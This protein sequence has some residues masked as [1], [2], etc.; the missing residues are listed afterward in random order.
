MLER[1]SS[2]Y[3]KTTGIIFLVIFVLLGVGLHQVVTGQGRTEEN[4]VEN[5]LTCETNFQE[6]KI[7]EKAGGTNDRIYIKEKAEED[8]NEM[9]TNNKNNEEKESQ[10]NIDIKKK[11]HH[12]GQVAKVKKRE[13][14][15]SQKRGNKKSKSDKQTGKSEERRHY[16]KKLLPD[17]HSEPR[18]GDAT[19]IV[20]HFS[21]N[22]LHKPENPYVVDDIYHIF[23]D[24][25]VS[26]H[27]LIDR[28][29]TIYQF[30][31]EKRVAWHA[32][33]GSLPGYPEYTDKLNH[34]SIGIELLGIGTEEE[35]KEINPGINYSKIN[36]SFIGF[37]DAQY[38][39]LRT[40]INDI[41]SRH[42][43][44]SFDRKH[45]IGHSDYTTRKP[46]PGVLFDWS[47]IGL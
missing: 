24:A 17:T 36:P 39:T 20:I 9:N 43:A 30:V 13:E 38:H 35:M 32:G 44:I 37:T 12:P 34:Y 27:Y 25:G 15:T 18:S 3:K 10:R 47:K 29:G 8:E 1:L 16:I 46:D 11:V 28:D 31:D 19:H 40:L 22:A 23:L 26:T 45:I 4:R 14:K 41:I 6:E 42:L 2:L 33:K 5:D 21:S 7:N